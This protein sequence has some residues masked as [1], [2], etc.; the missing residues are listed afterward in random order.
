MFENDYNYMLMLITLIIF[1]FFMLKRI[2]IFQQ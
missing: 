1:T 2:T